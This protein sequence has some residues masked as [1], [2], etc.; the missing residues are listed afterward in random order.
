MI[1][2]PTLTNQL[3][4][5][6]EGVRLIQ[7]DAETE[8]PEVHVEPNRGLAGCSTRGVVATV[9]DR[10]SVSF[11]DPTMAGRQSALVWNKRRFQYKEI[12]CPAST[13][14]EIDERIAAPRLKMT[15]RAG[16]WATIE[17]GQNGRTVN[18][19]ADNLGCDRH[20]VNDAVPAYG[21]ALVEHPELRRR[22]LPRTRR[23]P[24]A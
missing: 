1:T 23:A 21:A 6:L 10:R 14:T 20:T 17:V 2:E 18:G 24:H 8:I 22:H 9:K 19:I 12:D 13:W 3:F 16:H 11:V 7:I 5:N 4:V 15:D